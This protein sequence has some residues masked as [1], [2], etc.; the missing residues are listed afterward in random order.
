M[1]LASFDID[2]VPQCGAFTANGVIP[3]QLPN[4]AHGSLKQ[5]LSEHDIDELKTIVNVALE[6]DAEVST[7]VPFDAITLRPVV[8][9][10]EKIICV[11]INYQSH[12][13]ET[14]RDPSEHP[15]IFTRWADTQ[16]AH[17]APIHIPPA[18]EKFDYEG[19]VAVVM[20]R[21]G[22]NIGVD[23]ALDFVAGVACYND[24]SVREWQR[25]TS[26][27]TP[28]KNFAGTGAFGPCLVT[29]DEL[30]TL[31]DLRLITRVNGEVRQDAVLDQMIFSIPEL[32]AYVSSFTA[33]APG[34]VIVTGTP[35]G[36]GL[37]R[38]PPEFLKSGDV[39]EVAIDGVS[40]LRNV[41][42]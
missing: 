12:R 9:D 42:Q 33:L 7:L 22:T 10:P 30:G 25:H 15:A 39:V 32:I 37:F 26:Q 28:G 24:L 18:A 5:M 21:A 34:D 19:E 4:G 2:G 3:V 27:W 8:P 31:G 41:V 20:S 13:A 11:G 40:Q 6:H 38:D 17:D 1:R 36:V 29:L 16:I 35:G 23:E 14:K